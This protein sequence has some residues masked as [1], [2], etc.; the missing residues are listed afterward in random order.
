MFWKLFGIISTLVL[1]TAGTCIALVSRRL[2]EDHRR[3]LR[4]SLSAN[5]NLL[6]PLARDL[7][8]GEEKDRNHDMLL[9]FARETGMGITIQ[10]TNGLVLFRS[11]SGP[12]EPPPPDRREIPPEILEASRDITGFHV[13]QRGIGGGE[14][15]TFARRIDVNEA[16]LGFLLLT[17]P[18]EELD[19]K[20]W[21]LSQL[22]W[23]SALISGLIAVLLAFLFASRFTA[24]LE[25]LSKAAEAIA[26]GEY[27]R[28][29]EVSAR[30]EIGALA[31]SIR[32]MRDELRERISGIERARNDLQTMLESIPEGVMAIDDQQRILF[33]NP[34]IGRLFG[35]GR[36]N[37]AGQ[38]IWEVLRHP[39]LLEAVSSTLA[40]W[41]PYNTEFEIHKP[42]R[43]LAFRGRALRVESGHGVII[44]LQDISELRRLERMRQDF[45]ANVSHELK[46]PLAAIKAFT[47]TLLDGVEDRD[48]VTRFLRR[49]EEQAER[50]H[51]LVIDMLMLARVESEDHGFD[52][53]P[54]AMD[55]AVRACIE[56]FQG[57]ADA[58]EIDLKADLADDARWILADGEGLSM[59]LS[60][61][62]DNALKYTPARGQVLLRTERAAEGIRLHV[63]DTGIGIPDED[64]GRVFERFYRVDKARSRQL[65]GTGLGLSI[66]KH[67]AQT[68]GGTVSVKSRVSRGSTFTV[69][70]SPSESP[71]ESATEY[72]NV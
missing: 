25:D 69:V 33:A 38:R 6:S 1:I 46:T 31:R 21:E 18:A 14:I 41:N 71:T 56:S 24:R 60:N 51:A 62:V 45:F 16:T 66:V 29:I 34:S 5:A 57:E 64:L 20:Q 27:D 23:A 12:L 47:E 19:R 67:L 52:V 15:A 61:L 32:R 65:G 50:L 70:F 2:I 30:D 9:S 10:S 11:P 17:V 59:I 26:R 4:H 36:V 8:V 28:A 43:M 22:L 49:I 54:V 7:L 42:S 58:K 63:E 37:L 13:G 3:E 55:E 39:R 53:G 48:T 72:S 44:V 40:A 68:F 35:I